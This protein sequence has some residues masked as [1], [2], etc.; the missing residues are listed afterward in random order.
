MSTAPIPNSPAVP[1]PN[2]WLIAIAVMSGTFMEVLDTTVVNVSL[3][4]HRRQPLRHHRRS[5]LDAD[6]L[7][8]GQRH[9][10]SDDRLAC[11]QLRAQTPADCFRGRLYGG[12]FLVRLGAL[13]GLPDFFPG[14]AGRL[15]GRSAAAF[16]GHSAGSVSA[17]K[18]AARPWASGDWAS[19]SRPCWGRC[20]ADG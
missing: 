4:A 8:G 9:C 2:P 10:S 14:G 16:A 5:H 17:R 15:R 13:A 18:N 7:S 6:L 3:A 1:S 11:Q 19:W 20:W 12:I